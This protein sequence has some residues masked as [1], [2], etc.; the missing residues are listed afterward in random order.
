VLVLTE[1]IGQPVVDA[2]GR[3]LGRLRELV[4][5]VNDPSASVVRLGMR[6]GRRALRWAAWD[7]VVSFERTSVLLRPGA[8][9]W[10]EDRTAT[11]TG[12]DAGAGTD[13]G[14]GAGRSGAAPPT[15]LWLCRDVLDA[16]ILDAGGARLERVGDLVLV[17]VDHQVRVLAVQF[18]PGPVLRRLG[19]RRLAPRFRTVSVPWR[20]LHLVSGR[21]LAAQLAAEPAHL[22]L[23][24]EAQLAALI[25]QVSSDRAST[26]L[27]AVGPGRAADALRLAHP[28]V[29]SRV[30]HAL[31]GP[32]DAEVVAAMPADDAAAALRRVAPSRRSELLARLAPERAAALRS[33]VAAHPGT[34]QGLMTTEVTTAPAGTSVETLR[35]V[36]L[37]SAG[38]SHGPAT[39]IV[40]DP[41]GRPVGTVDA[42]D[43]LRPG[44]APAPRSVPV[45]R[46]TTPVDDVI[47]LFATH[48]HL[49]VPVVDADGRVIGA[50][51]IEDVLEHLVAE[52]LPGRSRF[53]HL[54]ARHRRSAAEHRSHR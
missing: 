5:D 32:F 44:T 47:E 36:L 3:V 51:S 43:L 52:R 35:T 19:L 23:L 6:R 42:T 41:D 13:G 27:N 9:V 11:G 4:V 8:P 54:L 31:P 38:R 39:V 20:E 53:H 29:R 16:Q 2:E 48:D 28:E 45:L 10:A 25:A 26:V 15:E 24:S 30:V 46:A 14:T 50:V 1:E 17:R 40:V 7:D 34:A 22:D 37:A 18:G 33:L 49:T 12:P 21:G